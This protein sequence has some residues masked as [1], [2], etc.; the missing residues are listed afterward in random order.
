MQ[1]RQAFRDL[2]RP[3]RLAVYPPKV[4]PFNAWSTRVSQRS[5]FQPR[6]CFE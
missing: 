6:G 4:R 3:Q 5:D 2:L 1:L